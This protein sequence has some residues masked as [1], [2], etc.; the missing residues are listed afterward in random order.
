MHLFAHITSLPLPK[1]ALWG[2]TFFFQ[3]VIVILLMRLATRRAPRRWVAALCALVIV[4]FSL[5][6]TAMASANTSFFVTTGA[7]IHWRQVG[8][9]H[10]DAAAIATLLTGLAG[11]LITAAILVA[12][13]WVLSRPIHRFVGGILHIL[14]TPYRSI[15]GRV[16]A[17]RQRYRPVQDPVRDEEEIPVEDYRDDKSDDGEDVPLQGSGEGPSRR[18]AGRDGRSGPAA[19]EPAAW[20]QIVTWGGLFLLTALRFLRP[21]DTAFVFLAGTLPVTPFLHTERPSPVDTE[22]LPGI[23]PYLEDGNSLANPPAWSWLPAG[24]PAGFRDWWDRSNGTRQHYSPASDPLHIANLQLPVLEP[25][26]ESLKNGSVQIKHIL[27]LKLESTRNDVFPLVKDSWLDKHIGRSWGGESPDEVKDRLGNLTRT[28]SYLTGVDPGYGQAP[29]PRGRNYGGVSASNAFTTGTYTLKSVVGSLCGVTPLVA[30]FNREYEYHIYQPCLAQVFGA[31]GQLPDAT[32]KPDDF[33][34]WPWHSTWMQSVT[35][36]YDNQDKLT[37]TMGY[38]DVLTKERI[39][40]PAAK[41]Y[42]PK[43]REVNYYGFADTELHEYVR[44]AIDDAERNHERLF[45]TH[46]TGTSHHPWGLPRDDMFQELMK[47]SNDDFNRYLNTIGFVDTWLADVLEI[48]QEKGV[49]DETLI[50]MAGD[51]GLSLPNDGGVTPYDNPHIG[52]FHVPIVLAHPKL[53]PVRVDAPVTSDQIV[54]TVLDLL[55]ESGSLG[56]E[57]TKATRDL[58]GQYEGQSMIR[59]L[60]PEKE[61]IQDWQFS[62]MNTGGSLI[63][64]R[65]AAHPDYRLVIPLV[66]D[67]EWRFTHVGEDPA[68]E[69][70]VKHFAL[71]DMAA[72]LERRF[73]KDAVDWL[74]DAA[75]VTEWW[76][77]ENWRRYGYSKEN[78]KLADGYDPN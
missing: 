6:M 26:R 77:T 19:S 23:Y 13:A 22:G 63:A 12:A 78:D 2:I 73:G 3:D 1:M 36:S 48:L 34:T 24:Q 41:H 38:Q 59:P 15:V 75:H 9:F 47:G 10:A 61:H 67:L 30:D 62:V 70:P 28:A 52:N 29:D 64:V 4:P 71:V 54:P 18:Y 58:R 66:D 7:E 31:L 37:P 11:F 50:V 42:P 55:V 65:S 69:H 35:D 14:G 20:K 8:T 21:S 45:L 56:P 46:L 60:V 49:A 32:R 5:G 39:N 17:R 74:R 57:G 76:V 33:R 16:R 44:D 40:D 51:H 72:S 25:L 68:E 43:T 53:P 27:F